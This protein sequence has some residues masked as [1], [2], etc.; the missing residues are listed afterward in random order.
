MLTYANMNMK[1]TGQDYGARSRLKLML[2]KLK[3]MKG[4]TLIYS[5]LGT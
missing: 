5:P 2:N 4:S 1:R 3:K